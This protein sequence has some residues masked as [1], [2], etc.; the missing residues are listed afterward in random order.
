[1]IKNKKLYSFKN[2]KKQTGIPIGIY[3]G[4]LSHFLKNKKNQISIA[5]GIYIGVLA[6]MV[7]AADDLIPKGMTTLV[8]S[9]KDVFVGPFV[10][11]ILVIIFCGAGVAYAFNRDNDKIKLKAIAIGVAIGI[12]GGASIIVEK[13]F[14]A[15][16]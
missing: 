11:A 6:Q 7:F 5:I 10:R 3:I 14:A 16:S 8:E 15:A 12:I 9:I 4:V 13:L 1:M 2:K